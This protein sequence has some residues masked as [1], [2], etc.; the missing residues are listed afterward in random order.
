[1]DK[2]EFGCD[3]MW[4][5]KQLALLDRDAG[6]E[7]N[8]LVGF[9]LFKKETQ[10]KQGLIKQRWT[11]LAVAVGLV[12]LFVLVL[13]FPRVLAHRCLE[14]SV[15][16]WQSLAQ[17]NPAPANLKP[18]G[19]RKL[20]PDFNLK[21]AEGKD[22]RLAAL[23][24]GVVVVN[25][26]ATWCHGCQTEIPSFIEFEKKYGNRG[27]TIIGI[28]MDDDGW[29][30]VRPWIKEKGVNYP[31]VIG[32]KDLSQQY[33]LMGM[34]LSVLVDREGRIANSHSGVVDTTAFEQQ[35]QELLNEDSKGSV[36]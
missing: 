7:P 10:R 33:G 35:V 18:E 31:I 30:S 27:L 19:A 12:C 16:V 5:D 21:D 23:K 8:V 15:A 13:P 20:A 17:S 14:C 22:V 4:V 3:E 28:S 6:R 2:N 34:P 32:N 29:K 25:F 1:M 11:W 36:D 9:A 24:G 26:W